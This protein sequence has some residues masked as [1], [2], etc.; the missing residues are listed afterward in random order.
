MPD[1]SSIWK[2]LRGLFGNEL[3]QPVADQKE[4]E[5]ETAGGSIN[6]AMQGE[7]IAPA[8]T[9]SVDLV[10]GV[11][12]GTSCTKVVIGDPGW[13]DRS[14]A[15]P[16]GTSKDIA[17][18]LFPT[19]YGAETNLKMRLM[20]DPD[21][22]KVRDILACYLAGVI[23]HSCSWFVGNSPPDYR[24]KEICWSLNLGFP[25]KR[26]TASTLA[27]AYRQVAS[28]AVALASQP[29]EPSLAVAKRFREGNVQAARVGSPWRIELYPEI[30]AQLAGYIN[31]PYRRRGNLILVDVGAGT[32]DVSTIILHGNAEQ[33]VVSFHFCEVELLGALRLCA[34]RADAL[35]AIDPRCLKFPL[36]HFQDG[37]R[38][39][40]DA[41]GEMVERSSPRLEK[42]FQSVSSDF[43]DR[44]IRAAL[45]CLTQFRCSQKEI[46]QSK[47]FDP[48]GSNLR[49]FLT[50]G[51]SRSLFYRRALA[52]GPLEQA[53]APFTRWHREAKQRKKDRQGLVLEPLPLPAKLENFPS[54]LRAEF[55]RLSVAY[56]LAYGG[57][58]LSRVTSSVRS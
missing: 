17:N 9:P 49:F 40:P 36:E 42:A 50:G 35:S 38:P 26:V 1:S 46:H 3:K 14:F 25:E 43:A 23:R 32:L 6:R 20:D 4:D 22:E 48:W 21:S 57:E 31:S 30:A 39:V 2:R 18:W 41:L 11:D 37:S 45:I 7:R 8:S 10:L 29:E 51:G 5:G 33:D 52:D 55:D 19:R 54:A 56:G 13:K 16:F 58:N 44:V 24:R 15:V 34:A 28:V 53:L 47:N 27:A 12:L